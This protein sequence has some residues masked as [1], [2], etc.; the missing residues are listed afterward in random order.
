[1]KGKRLEQACNRWSVLCRK[2]SPGSNQVTFDGL[3]ETLCSRIDR[4]QASKRLRAL[5]PSAAP[6]KSRKKSAAKK[7]Q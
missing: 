7:R 2:H 1:M 3:T 4:D 6:V 5:I